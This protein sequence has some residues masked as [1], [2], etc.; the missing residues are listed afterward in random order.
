MNN[1][2]GKLAERIG[3]VVQDGMVNIHQ[4]LLNDK[5]SPYD[6]SRQ[7]LRNRKYLLK[8]VRTTWVEGVLEKSLYNQISIVLRLDNRPSAV[9]SDLNDLD[10]INPD[11]SREFLPAGTTAINVFDRLGDG[12]KLL[13]LGAPGAGKTII[14]LQLAKDL[15]TRA[16]EDIHHLIP[17]VLN[18]SSW[19]AKKQTIAEW[20]VEELNSQYKL[21]RK[22][23]QQWVEKQELLL[24]LDGLDEIG[25]FEKRNACVNAL[26]DF[27]KETAT[28]MVVCCRKDHYKN[29]HYKLKLE[30]AISLQPLTNEQ[31]ESYLNCLQSNLTLLKTLLSSDTTLQELAQSPLW[32][33]IMV[34]TY[35]DINV[36]DSPVDTTVSNPKKKLFDDYLNRMFESSRPGAYHLAF[37]PRNNED[38]SQQ[39]STRWLVWMAQQM[40]RHSQSIFLIEKMQPYWLKKIE[41]IFHSILTPLIVSLILTLIILPIEFLFNFSKSN[42]IDTIEYVIIRA[43]VFELIVWLAGRWSLQIKTVESVQFS[44]QQFKNKFRKNLFFSLKAGLILGMI[45]TIGKLIISLINIVWYG[46]DGYFGNGTSVHIDNLIKWLTSW[47]D[48]GLF[49]GL[50][51]ELILGLTS[52]IISLDIKAKNYPNQGIIKSVM[53]ALFFGIIGGIIIGIIF[54]GINLK[55]FNEGHILINSLVENR[56]DLYRGIIEAGLFWGFVV[57]LIYGGRASIK[58]LVLRLILFLT[59]R[60]PWNYSKF[61]DWASDKLFLQKVGG[62]YIFIHRSL[63]EHFSKIENSQ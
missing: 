44:W 60:T 57:G 17:V 61:L 25:D 62:G 54:G 18:L 43:S 39:E 15:I 48:L 55:H 38:Y 8:N 24:L 50:I 11:Q 63:M 29:L 23:G 10:I 49:F 6:M 58:H 20:I 4:I 1:P 59:R 22:I 31:I 2:I 9:N 5:M 51:F 36:A 46:F 27:Q 41:I 34:L 14:L 53:N 37:I 40:F 47:L 3:V 28:E 13:I 19:A 35:K 33:N 45:F 42:L 21:P 7:E 16:E 52:G 12:R 26:N 32:L 30:S 56:K